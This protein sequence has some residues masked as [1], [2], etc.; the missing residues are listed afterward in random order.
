MPYLSSSIAPGLFPARS[1]TKYA[2]LKVNDIG[3]LTNKPAIFVKLTQE[4]SMELKGVC[5]HTN[6]VP[7]L[8]S[9]YSKVLNLKAEG[10]DNHSVFNEV[11]LAIW[12]PGY[13]DEIRSKTSDRFLTLMFEVENVDK[14]YQRLKKL[15][16]FILFTSEPTDYD[17]G[18]RA[19]GFKDPDGNDVDFLSQTKSN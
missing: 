3:I 17:L 14:E 11:K 16:M 8:V 10:D 18:C 4:S 9:F 19:F 13:I 7:G 15:D 5:I 6:N 2:G 12:N 1:K